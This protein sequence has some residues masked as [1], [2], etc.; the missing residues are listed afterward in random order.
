MKDNGINGCGSV[1]SYFFFMSFMVVLS[2]VVM[3]LSI[4]AVIDGL[5]EA[6]NDFYSCVG[7]T[8]I[9]ELI[10]LWKEYDP[11]ATGWVE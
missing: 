10:E 1:S 6:R 9:L 2:M 5:N 7:S 3:N 8:D 4:A 11:K